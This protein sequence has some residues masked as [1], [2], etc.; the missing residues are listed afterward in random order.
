MNVILKED[1]EKLGT[2]GEKVKVAD[3]Y[4]RNWLLPQGFAIK[5]NAAAAKVIEEHMKGRAKKLAAQKV[6]A[7]RMAAEMSKLNLEFVRRTG[8]E[9][10]LYGSVTAA[11]IGNAIIEKGFNIDRRK[12][13]LDMPVK[14]LGEHKIGVKLHPE[15]RA[16]ITVTVKAEEIS[17]EDIAATEALKKKEEERTEKAETAEESTEKTGE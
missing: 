12:V 7:E 5:E 15:V 14:T 9:G 4:A 17:A 16:E 6:D 1:I 13:V 8:E 11:E 3:G 2:A 10:K